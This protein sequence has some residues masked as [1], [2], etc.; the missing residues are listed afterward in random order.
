MRS[1]PAELKEQCI[2]LMIVH[3]GF[4][5]ASEDCFI[6]TLLTKSL[7]LFQQSALGE[8]LMG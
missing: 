4:E 7:R 2:V 6:A 1:K 5:A 3:A 8:R